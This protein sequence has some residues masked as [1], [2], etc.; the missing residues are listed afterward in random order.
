MQNLKS[1]ALDG[2]SA[3]GKST[4][5]KRISEHYSFIYVDTGA[6]YRCIG[7]F[8]LRHNISISDK[9]AITK[10]LP[11]ITIKLF[12][13][14][15]GVQRMLLCDEDVTEDIRLPDVSM[16]ASAVSAIPSVRRYLL[17]TQKEMARS[18]DV[19]M[20][21]R[22]IGTVVLPDACL[23]IFLTAETNVRAN[24]RF[25]E[26]KE[27]SI[28][29]SFEEVLADISLRDKNDSERTIAPLKPAEDAVIVDT[30]HLNFE[31][32]FEAICELIN[33]R[34]AI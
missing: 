2:P 12:Y 30:T 32:S 7:L 5:A 15:E 11:S 23:K 4:L 19:V 16:A 9:D 29:T 28:D 25:L 8:V 31:E 10:I 21:G 22:D 13:D 24:R 26:L 14:N 18:Y 1:I 17:E 34:F 20:D 33:R 27:K 3:A 6:L